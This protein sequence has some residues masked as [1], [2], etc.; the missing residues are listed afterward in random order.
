MKLINKI[1]QMTIRD[2]NMFSFVNK[3]VVLQHKFKNMKKTQY[4][5]DSTNLYT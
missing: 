2:I 1:H 3:T 4:D 5:K